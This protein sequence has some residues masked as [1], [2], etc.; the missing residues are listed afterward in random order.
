MASRVPA[1]VLAAFPGSPSPLIDARIFE[2]V[3]FRRPM[4]AG[5]VPGLVAFLRA[6][7]RDMEPLG[8]RDLVVGLSGGLDSVV[9]ARLCQLAA[10]GVCR[11]SAVTVDLGRAGEA[12][13]VPAIT[14]CASRLG[15]DHHVVS[16]QRARETI[17]DSSPRS[18]PWSDI[19]TDT[20]L[21]QSFLFRAADASAASVVSTTDLSERLLGRHTEGFYGQMEP[22]GSLYK[23]EVKALAMTLGVLD[24]LADDRPGC[25]DYWYDDEVLGVDYDVVDPVLHLLAAGRKSPEWIAQE[26]GIV[27]V[28]WVTRVARRVQLQPHRLKTRRPLR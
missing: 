8:L 10:V 16:G 26:F 3:R 11:V 24:Q 7:I 5:A 21:I 6:G 23:T 15:L 12:D 2:G 28:G 18:G 14:A 22:L 20:R 1:E 25:E 9:V 4:D 27:D 19:N 13:R 17:I